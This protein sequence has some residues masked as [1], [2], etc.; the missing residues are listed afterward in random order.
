MQAQRAKWMKETENS[1]SD[2]G[3]TRKGG[4]GEWAQNGGGGFMAPLLC[5]AGWVEVAPQGSTE[6]AF[7]FVYPF[8]LVRVKIS[9]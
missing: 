5:K 7:N 8:E 4:K 2:Q 3:S 9:I 1:T 6:A